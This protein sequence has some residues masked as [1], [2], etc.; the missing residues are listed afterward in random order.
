MNFL[1]KRPRLINVRAYGRQQRI[2]E[3]NT[4]HSDGYGETSNVA[5]LDT[6]TVI[7]QSQQNV[8]HI[9]PSSNLLVARDGTEWTLFVAGTNSRGRRL[10]QNILR[11]C[12]GATSYARKN[13]KTNSPASAWRLIII[14]LFLNIFKVVLL[15]EAHRQA[16]CKDFTL[17]FSFLSS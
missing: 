6:T 2:R 12:P 16:K 7:E 15:T 4:E 8:S 5:V 11:E 17:S 9:D 14:R 1:G 3:K 10:Q 13:V